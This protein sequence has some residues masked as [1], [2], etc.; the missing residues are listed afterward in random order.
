[1]ASKE[2]LVALGFEVQHSTAS[3]VVSWGKWFVGVRHS[4][5]RIVAGYGADEESAFADALK[6]VTTVKVEPV[7]PNK[8]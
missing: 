2:E 1:M 6:T 3:P 7:S 5:G 4:N 8:H